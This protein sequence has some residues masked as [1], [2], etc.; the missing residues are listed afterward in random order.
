MAMASWPTRSP[1]EL[2]SRTAGSRAPDTRMSAR[3]VCGSSPTRSASV[4][5]PSLKLTSSLDAPPATWLLV[6]I[7]PSGVK[8]NPEPLPAPS[9]V[10]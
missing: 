1:R 7:R 3:S 4:V 5:W 8:M 2:P 9:R 6:R 10:P